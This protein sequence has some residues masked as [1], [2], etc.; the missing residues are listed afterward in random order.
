MWRVEM[1]PATCAILSVHL[2]EP[3]IPYVILAGL[4]TEACRE[5]KVSP[6]VA[7]ALII[8]I[9]LIPFPRINTTCL[10]LGVCFFL[11]WL[12]RFFE[13]GVQPDLRSGELV[14]MGVFLGALLSIKANFTPTL[15]MGLVALGL[16]RWYHFR[17]ARDRLVELA[18][19]GGGMAI[20]VV[21][22][23]VALLGTGLRRLHPG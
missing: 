22:W 4:V 17:H 6:W 7:P 12:Q 23:M 5:R 9:S 14:W 3:A 11:V 8:V 16:I 20:A 2:I 19:L 13:R 1:G 15:G 10:V 21:P 18:K